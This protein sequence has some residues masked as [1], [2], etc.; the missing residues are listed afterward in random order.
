VQWS[1]HFTT[2][3]KRIFD[4][5]KNP[6]VTDNYEITFKKVDEVAVRAILIGE[7]EFGEERIEKACGN[8]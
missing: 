8:T 1:E 3:W 7:H 6:A 2:D 5:I 4:L